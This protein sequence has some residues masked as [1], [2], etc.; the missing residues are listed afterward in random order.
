MNALNIINFFSS[1]V[2]LAI[3]NMSIEFPNVNI[4]IKLYYISVWEIV[5]CDFVYQVVYETL[6]V[7]I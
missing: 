5:E 7:Y 1:F 2:K 4:T 6:Y 3:V